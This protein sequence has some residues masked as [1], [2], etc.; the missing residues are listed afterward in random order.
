[1]IIFRALTEIVAPL[2]NPAVTIGNFD[3][4]HLGHREIF[5]R[6]KQAARE[7]GGVSVVVTFAPHPLKVVPTT[8]QVQLINTCAEKETLIAASGVD[9]LLVIPFDAAFAALTPREFVTDVLV[10]RIGVKRLIIGHDYA[11]GRNREGNAT[12]L[13][14]L[15][16]EFGFAVEELPPIGK[17]GTVY[18]STTVRNLVRSGAVDQVVRFLGRHYSLGGTV[19][20][21]EHRGAGLG[22]PTANLST[23]KEL[24]PADGVYA[25][26]VKIDDTIYDGACNI[27]ANPTFGND[28]TSIEVF[29]FDFSGQLYGR[30]VRLYFVARLREER[31]FPSVEELRQ[32]IA[33]DVR[34]CRELLRDVT[35]IEY[36]EYLEGV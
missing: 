17:E 34:R 14:Q 9:Y 24:I 26:K 15:G 31:K 27:G 5:R 3:G 20:H 35:I 19:V 36:R 2:P 32:T 21:G 8:K 13:Q 33:D 28:R 12:L 7:Q 23:D 25:V 16:E 10:G 4:V 6:V 30:E 22:F 11:F 18:S 29:I 1:M